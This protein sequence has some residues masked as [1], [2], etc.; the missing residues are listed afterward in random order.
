MA[1]KDITV[2]VPT[3]NSELWLDTAI[4]SLNRQ[5][6][7]SFIAVFVDDCSTDET[8]YLLKHKLKSAARFDFEVIEHTENTGGMAKAVHD[9]F[10]DCSTRFYTWF[11]VDDELEPEYLFKLRKLLLDNQ[12]YNYAYCHYRIINTESVHIGRWSWKKI[13]YKE[14]VKHIAKTASGCMPMN[15]LIRARRFKKL[16]VGFTLFEDE[17]FSFDTLNAIHFSANG[18]KPIL[19]DDYLFL[20]RKHSKQGSNDLKKRMLSD[21]NILLFIVKNHFAALDAKQ[22]QP[23][24]FLDASKEF[25]TISMARFADREKEILFFEKTIDYQSKKNYCL[26][27]ISNIITDKKRNIS[28]GS[29]IDKIAF[30]Y[31][32]GDRLSHL[33]L[34]TLTTITHFNP[35][36]RIIVYTD[37]NDIA[38]ENISYS[39]HEH[40]VRIEKAYPFTAIYRFFNVEV[41]PVDFEKNYGIAENLFHSY[42]ADIIRIKKLEE[43][44]GLWF[45]MDILFLKP[46]PKQLFEFY[47][48]KTVKVCSYSNTI[49]TGLISAKLG[50]KLIKELSKEADAYIK[51]KTQTNFSS[52]ESYK[53][54][55]QAFGPDLWRKKIS[56]YLDN[57]VDEHPSAEAIPRTLVYPY[58]WNEMSEY[59]T[60]KKISRVNKQNTLGIHWYNG[61]TE[62]RTFINEGMGAVQDITVAK[63]PFEHDFLYLKSKGVDVA[64]PPLSDCVVSLRGAMLQNAKLVSASFRNADL[65]YANLRNADLRNAAL[66][67]ADLRGA[68]LEGA[69][70][71][72]ADLSNAILDSNSIATAKSKA[73]FMQN[74]KSPAAKGA[75]LGISIVMAAYNRKRQLEPVLRSIA[76]QKYPDLEVIIVDDASESSESLDDLVALMSDTIDIRLVKVLP[77]EKTWKNPSAA[78]NIGIG[79]ARKDV[80]LL[81]N[82]EVMHC[83]SVLQHI[84][85]NIKPRDWLTL[86]CYGLNED[87]T[88][89]VYSEEIHASNMYSFIKNGT[90]KIGGNSVVEKDPSG[91][92]NHFDM[93]FVAYHYCG[94]ILRQDIDRLMGGGFSEDFENLVGGDDDEF[95]KRLVYNK[96]NF[97]IASFKESSPF[98]VHLYHDKTKAVCK[99]G[100]SDYYNTSIA[101]TKKLVSMG[102]CPEIDIHIAPL[103]ETPMGR[104]VLL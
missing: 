26:A 60:G 80:V 62:A 29:S 57:N 102:F 25:L 14:L 75:F 61:S 88:E 100:E 22:S 76:Q 52:E 103:N 10:A 44:G 82:A 39:S 92:L 63:T 104:R 46:L 5:T 36:T 87:D 78:Y 85:E 28:M 24:F 90:Q 94:A 38:S 35:D 49:A 54:S 43:H 45:D 65:R 77:E 27:R 89:R 6:C 9:T 42:Y 73:V 56:P 17:V 32:S 95:V 50:C 1:A 101:L 71:Q 99:W 55:Y 8:V 23:E 53:D 69:N 18:L 58:L 59:F 67:G 96:F 74:D 79:Y 81:Q 7:K 12:E 68:I 41:V 15:G 48:Q 86:N 64:E 91:W 11:A 66:S 21:L 37:K 97:K 98:V 4:A 93:H 84:A 2:C 19:L 31:W 40:K 13:G 20:Y 34:L 30:T 16:G 3:Y 47:G 33:H 51:Q 70:L 72:G 83:G